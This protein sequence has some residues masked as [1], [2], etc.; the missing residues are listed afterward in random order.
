MKPTQELADALFRAKVL[1]ARRRTP[2]ER[3]TAGGQLSDE[4]RERMIAGIRAR[5]PEADDD[6][7]IEILK[8]WLRRIRQLEKHDEQQ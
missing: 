7:V 1:A 6:R 4:V 5:Y 3:M 2:G 8:T